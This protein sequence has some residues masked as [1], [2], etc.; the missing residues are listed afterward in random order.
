MDG[1]I[2]Q[3]NL[4]NYLINKTEHSAAVS[5]F[6]HAYK[7]YTNFAKDTREVYFKNGF[8]FGKTASFRFDEDGKYGDLITNVIV[9]IDL[10][11][12]STLTNINGH[13]VGYCN[14]IGNALLQNITLRINGNIIDQHI[15]E[16]MNIYGD[17]TVKPGCRDNYYSMIQQ[18]DDNSFIPTTFQGGRIYVPLQFWFCRNITARN[19]AMVF[20]LLSFFNSTIELSM[21]VRAF[22]NVITTE[23]GILT[24]IPNQN[25]E[26][27]SLFVDYVILD[28]DE[29][30]RYLAVPKQLNIINQMQYYQYDVRGGTT[31]ATFSLKRMHYLVSEII[32]VM[33]SNTAESSNDYFNYS[34]S[35]IPGN[36]RNMIRNVRLILD[37]RDR[38]KTTPASVFTQIEPSKVHSNVPINKFIHVYSFALEPERLEQPSGVMNFSEIQEP[39]LHLEFNTG[40][41]SSL[42]YVFA[43]NY[44]V[45]ISSKGTGWLLHH[46][47]K[48]IPTVFP[49]AEVADSKCE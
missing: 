7:N 33:R 8:D 37:G 14:G 44:N 28:D 3:L 18:Y 32:F 26:F 13:P 22:N 48:S 42:L 10:P 19:S 45:L 34:S 29:R 16:F 5:F 4:S 17:L 12:I 20:P 27:A 1:S 49:S 43:V 9:A 35:Q 30:Q 31:N 2:T 15:S 38:I 21:D 24:G 36:K 23:D 46:L 41:P 11:D 47:S 40:I 25:I 39:L 6:R